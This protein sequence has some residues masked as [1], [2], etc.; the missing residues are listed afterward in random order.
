MSVKRLFHFG[1]CILALVSATSCGNQGPA[2]Q[3]SFF[4]NPSEPPVITGNFQVGNNV[5]QAPWFGFTVT[6]TNNSND[7]VT[8]IGIQL[9]VNGTRADGS[10]VSKTVTISPSDYNFSLACAG[11]AS[12]EIQFNDFGEIGPGQTLP[13]GLY[14]RGGALPTGCGNPNQTTAVIMYAG[15]GP[16]PTADQVISYVYNV[17]MIP[18]GWFGTASQPDNRLDKQVYFTT[19]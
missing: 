13:L 5:I 3:V 10:I 8:I 17:Q 15:P 12:A 14:Y 9:N 19:E 7:T 2:S 18:L 6:V 16:S 4:I 11:G 1:A